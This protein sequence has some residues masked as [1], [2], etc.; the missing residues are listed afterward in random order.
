MVIEEESVR[1]FYSVEN[2][3][4]Y[5]KEDPKYLEIEECVAPAIEALIYKYPNYIP[6]ED[7]PL[8]NLEEQVWVS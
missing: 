8:S 1:L 5:H 3:R 7:L 4:E 2:S 6:I